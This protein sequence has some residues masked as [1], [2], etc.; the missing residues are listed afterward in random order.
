MCVSY[1]KFYN[2]QTVVDCDAVLSRK[3]YK[4]IVGVDLHVPRHYLET[5]FVYLIFYF[6]SQAHVC[7]LYFWRNLNLQ[8]EIIERVF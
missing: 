7:V 6:A 1:S 4:S 8:V 5:I 2:F 3:Y